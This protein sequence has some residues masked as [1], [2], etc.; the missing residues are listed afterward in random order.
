[1]C[2]LTRLLSEYEPVLM[3]YL[4]QRFGSTRLAREITHET[5]RQLVDSEILAVVG[6]PQVYVTGYALA[7][8]LH[9]PMST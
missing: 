8:G 6:N 1:M 3:D 9:W 7:V 2:E 4:T 5:C